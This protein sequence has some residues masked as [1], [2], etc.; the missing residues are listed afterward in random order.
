MSYNGSGLFQ[1]NTAGQPVVGGTTI[2]PTVFNALTA[3]LATGLS[4]VI[5]KDGQTT[6]TANIP[7]GNNKITGLAAATVRT[8]AASLATIQDGTG[9]YVATVGGTADVITLTPS[10]AIS[11]YVAGQ[12]FRFLAAGTN[13]TNVTVNIS[14]LGAKAI[15][16][17]GTTALTAGDIQSGEMVEITYDG[18]R[19][20]L[21]KIGHNQADNLF[22]VVG[23]SDAT[24]RV[25][26]EVDGLTTA[27]TRTVTV[28]DKSGTMAMI[29]DSS[30]L[31]T[32][33]N[34]TS[35][36]QIDFTG[37]P[38]WVRE[39]TVT[40]SD[41]STSGATDYLVL[42]IGDSGGVETTSYISTFSHIINGATTATVESRTDSFGFGFIDAA[43]AYHGAIT[44]SLLNAS[45]NMWVCHG[46][47][48]SI[49]SGIVIVHSAGR[50]ALSATLD[51]VRVTTVSGRT[52]DG[53][54]INIIYR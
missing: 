44:L 15:T 8:D 21:G 16:K 23:S 32:P 22:R 54:Q 6:P 24:K 18:T 41:V 26:F 34:S 37:I 1:I 25:A 42:Q 12:T 36:T 38:S 43:S 50:K 29:G 40:L 5:C 4:N 20:I 45:T 3:D 35:G 13:T 51:R 28:P 2:D 30:N 33:V 10:P 48:S 19:F 9:V 27:T 46:V 11:S 17:N 49:G 53:G 39:I 52:F 47:L 14:S 7:M 31:G